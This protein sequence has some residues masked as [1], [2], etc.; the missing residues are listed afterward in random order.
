VESFHG[1]LLPFAVRGFRNEYSGLKEFFCLGKAFA[2][3]KGSLGALA[4]CMGF[5][6]IQVQLHNSCPIHAEAATCGWSEI[7]NRTLFPATGADSAQNQ[8]NLALAALVKLVLPDAI[9]LF[10]FAV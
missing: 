10:L 8:G 7:R 9:P 1:S 6:C 4:G 2:L 5:C 3:K